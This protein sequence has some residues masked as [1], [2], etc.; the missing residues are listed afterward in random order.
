MGKCVLCHF[1]K[2][3]KHKKIQSKYWG[4]LIVPLLFFRTFLPLW[5]LWKIDEQKKCVAKQKVK[6]EEKQ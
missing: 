3:K 1:D 5:F 4:R 6:M 2:Q